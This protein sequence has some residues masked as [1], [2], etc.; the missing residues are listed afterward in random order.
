MCAACHIAQVVTKNYH[1][2]SG[3]RDTDYKVVLC[4][5]SLQHLRMVIMNG[6]TRRTNSLEEDKEDEEVGSVL[7][8]V[9]CLWG[10]FPD[11][12][13]TSATSGD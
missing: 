7:V 1:T 8:P 11:K 4:C 13:C 6:R 9:P 3:V 10:D 12:R 2:T 5:V